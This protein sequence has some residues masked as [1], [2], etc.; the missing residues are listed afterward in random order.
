[1][2]NFMKKLADSQKYNFQVF[3][4]FVS[5]AALMVLQFLKVEVSGEVVFEGTQGFSYLSV[6]GA[7]SLS[8]LLPI[9]FIMK[10]SYIE[11]G[12]EE[13]GRSIEVARCLAKFLSLQGLTA[14]MLMHTG[15]YCFLDIY[16]YI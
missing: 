2:K 8:F 3:L 15:D 12:N 6:L 16:L 10:Y 5:I 7:F 1:M 13:L 4:L 9:G 14:L 11:E